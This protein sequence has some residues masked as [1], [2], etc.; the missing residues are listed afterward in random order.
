M[1]GKLK[2]TAE[3]TANI[4]RWVLPLFA[5]LVMV[6]TIVSVRTFDKVD[7][8]LFGYKIFIVLSDSMKATDFESG[9]LVLIKDVNPN[10]LTEG[11]IIAFISQE[12]E[13]YGEV[14]THKIRTI[15]EEGFV[16]Y[17]TTTGVD[18]QKIVTAPQ[19]I[20]K[21]SFSIPNVGSFFLFLK[22][23]AG[24]I[25]CILI[26]FLLMIGLQ[27][28][29]TLSLF[30]KYKKEKQSEMD[31]TQKENEEIRAENE[32]MRAELEMLRGKLAEKEE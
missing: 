5:A 32:E 26:P 12:E 24:Y 7:R 2:K 16:T 8:D 10:V 4:L 30:M 20:G 9:D 25:T 21:Y 11:D 27:L 29:Q 19:V 23:P 15:T 1:K 22:T 6:F 18:D 28:A 14:I 3:I 31:Q 13:S 17:G